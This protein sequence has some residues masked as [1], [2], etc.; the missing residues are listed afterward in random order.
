MRRKRGLMG[1]TVNWSD[2]EIAFERNSPDQESF[3]DLENG[4]LLSIVEGEPDAAA[5]RARVAGNPERYLRVDPA[6]SREQYRWMERFVTSVS[7]LTLRE[8][9]SSRSTAKG[10]FGASRTSCWRSRPSVSGGLPTGRSCCT[11]TSRLGSIT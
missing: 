7:E 5:R 1:I 4:D 2:L 6:S 8:R 10:R 3:L 9:F 11:F